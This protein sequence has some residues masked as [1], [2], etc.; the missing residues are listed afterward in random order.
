[1]TRRVKILRALGITGIFTG[2]ILSSVRA[3]TSTP[4][5]VRESGLGIVVVEGD[6]G[7]Q[8]A[9]TDAAETARALAA[10]SGL[11]GTIVA[12]TNPIPGQT[13]VA[14]TAATNGLVTKTVTNGLASTASVI[15][16]TNPIPSWIVAATNPIPAAIAAATNAMYYAP[17]H[18]LYVDNRRTD[19]FT[20]D[21]TV[22]RPYPTVSAAMTAIGSSQPADWE[23]V[24]L[25][26]YTVKVMPGTYVED[27]SVPWRPYLA[28][29]LSSAV[30]V[31]NVTRQIPNGDFASRVSTL[32][33]RGDSVRPAYIDGEHT[34]IGVAGT[35]IYEAATS[36]AGMSPF[37]ELQVIGAGI[38]GGVNYKG[39]LNQ[40]SMQ[41]GQIF[42][43]DSQVGA[44]V[45]TN[46][47]AGVSIFA[48]G[49]GGGHQGGG[50]AGSGVGPLIGKVL[51]YNLQSTMISGGMNLQDCFPGINPAQTLWHNVTFETN[52]IYNVS[53]VTYGVKLDTASYNS[54]LA[55]SLPS[56]RGVWKTT[57]G[58]KM[59]LSDVAIPP[60]STNGLS[61]GM[62]WNSNGIP[63]IVP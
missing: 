33:I 43:R 63:A 51:P 48:Y 13:A 11:A 45:S 39:T 49:W 25:R 41:S 35:V 4:V 12:S 38:S 26:Y 59:V 24:N 54:W 27:V 2:L 50:P 7:P 61:S 57:A 46:G 60:T 15:A 18:S 52:F 10:E 1:M 47:W 32:I 40:N 23:N 20:A 62:L 9:A 36:S 34:V 22:M 19:T 17:G 30:I 55:A 5:V 56:E 16:A 31:G 14:I 37:H 3:D 53:N 28:I 29:D 6:L 21:G 8:L 58:G 44:I 42:L